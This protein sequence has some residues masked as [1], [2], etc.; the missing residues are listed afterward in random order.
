ML[1]SG[2]FLD[3]VTPGIGFTVEAGVQCDVSLVKILL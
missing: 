1:P 2:T 3:K